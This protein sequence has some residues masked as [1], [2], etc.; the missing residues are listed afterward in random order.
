MRDAEVV[1]FIRSG[2]SGGLAAAYDEYG[3]LIYGYC[4]SLLGDSGEAVAAVLGTFVNAATFIRRLSD[5]AHFRAWLFA[6]A[7]NHCLP[8]RKSPEVMNTRGLSTAAG[9]E[10]DRM[11]VRAAIDGLAADE[12]DIL[13]LLW[14]G[15]EADEAALVLGLDRDEVYSQFS[16]ARDQLEAS[17]TALLVCYY[18][19][20]NCPELTQLTG[21]WNGT[22]SVWL[23]N[24][25]T[26]HVE[27][28][29]A[30]SSCR[31]RELR[32]ALLLNLT[33]GAL[34]G[35]AENARTTTRSAPPWLRD[36]LLWLVTTDDLQGETERRLRGRRIAAFGSNGFPGTRQASGTW[37]PRPGS[38]RLAAGAAAGIAVLA[39]VAI[40]VVSLP[41]G[42]TAMRTT[43]A[44]AAV[45]DT[46]AGL[47]RPSA[48]AVLPSRTASATP[49][50]THTSAS[51]TPGATTRS[52]TPS[53]M[54]TT[55]SPAPSSPS[56]SSLSPSATPAAGTLNVSPGEIHIGTHFGSQVT[57]TAQ[58]GPVTYSVSLTDHA[59]GRISVTPSAGHLN[60]GQSVSV[61]VADDSMGDFQTTLTI[62][63]GDEHVTVTVGRD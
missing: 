54:P 12:W 19:R 17:V 35:G 63:P 8:D 61:S 33:P 27:T 47:V 55:P 6:L 13:I 7:R 23:R 38:P 10:A 59:A 34:F 46:S 52:A 56:P 50:P 22:L 45:Q 39:V 32:P 14:H 24:E 21:D 16:R 40:V 48:V 53:P 29:T 3:D 57:L 25:V 2:D 62:S 4:G 41:S 42:K 58:G 28:C 60:A 18:G 1:E 49:S 15:L 26:R 43:G 9:T 37:L 30:C 44:G 51:P 11:L 5:P 20:G 36:R 31:D